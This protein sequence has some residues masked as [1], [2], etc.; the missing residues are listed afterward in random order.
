M[1]GSVLQD[2]NQNGQNNPDINKVRLPSGI[3]DETRDDT[4]LSRP[5]GMENALEKKLVWTAFS[6]E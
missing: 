5:P 6:G 3:L 4:I 1:T 2:N